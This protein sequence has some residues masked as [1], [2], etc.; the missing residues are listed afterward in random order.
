MERRE[1]LPRRET[2]GVTMIKKFLVLAVL[3][4][5]VAYSTSSYGAEYLSGSKGYR[6][7]SK[8]YLSGSKGLYAGIGGSVALENFDM[9]FTGEHQTLGAG[10]SWGVN[11]KVGYHLSNWFSLELDFNYLFEFESEERVIV[12]GIPVDS[13][14]QLR[15][16]T[17]MPVLKA[18]TGHEPVNPFFAV[19][20][21]YMDVA[22]TS[23]DS[24]NK[25]DI[26]AKVGLGIDFLASNNLSIG[27][28]A[29]YVFGMGD[30][31]D[32]AYWNFTLGVCYY[33]GTSR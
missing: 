2:K 20:L 25:S 12:S 15:I 27:I 10:E 23:S 11:G 17:I 14:T 8:G 1:I 29:D 26:A 32:I 4:V 6:S 33:F 22:F 13:E 19:G 18:C 16:F 24:Y 9:R 31:D 28:E 21:G 5:A 30:L 7:G 3:V